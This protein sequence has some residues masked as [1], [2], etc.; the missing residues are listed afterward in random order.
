MIR[1][2]DHNKNRGSTFTVLLGVVA[3][4]AFLSVTAYQVISGP[5]RTMAQTSNT[6]ITDLQLLSTGRILI[7]TVLNSPTSGNCDSDNFVEATPFVTPA[8]G[9]PAPSGGGVIP[10]T[11]I[12]ISDRDAFGTQIGY[13]VWD[14]GTDTNTGTCTGDN[15]LDGSNDPLAGAEQSRTAFA[16]ISAGPNRRFETTCHDF[17]SNPDLITNTA[18]SDDFIRRFNYEEAVRLSGDLWSISATDSDIVEIDRD[19]ELT[20]PNGL[21]TFSAN[22]DVRGRILARGGL[23]VG[24]EGDGA[25]CSSTDDAGTLRFNTSLS[26]LEFCDGTAFVNA[27]GSG[28]GHSSPTILTEQTIV[29]EQTICNGTVTGRL[30]Y[31]T[32]TQRLEFCDGIAFRALYTENNGPTHV[33]PFLD[34]PATPFL[35]STITGPVTAGNP[36]PHTSSTDTLFIDHGGGPSFGPITAYINNTDNFEIID[37]QCSGLTIGSNETDDD[38]FCEITARARTQ[39][40]VNGTFQGLLVLKDATTTVTY[41]LIAVIE[42]YCEAGTSA[43]GGVIAGCTDD[44]IYVIQPLGCGTATTNPIC[45]G[46]DASTARLQTAT[47]ST[48]YPGTNSALDGITNTTDQATDTGSIGFP[49]AEYCHDLVLNG[50]SDWFLPSVSELSLFFYNITPITTQYGIA[51]GTFTGSSGRM[52]TSSSRIPTPNTSNATSMQ[53]TFFLGFR[54]I[55]NPKTS[56]ERV[57]CMRRVAR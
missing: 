31:N 17:A 45:D 4:V 11:N 8:T 33:L 50:H 16:L 27:N 22:V 47:A 46:T 5:V 57:L 56:T 40:G 32:N 9:E 12:G 6:R 30:R 35:F 3:L 54:A 53:G 21:A 34:F 24:T 44:F 41:P 20:S 36:L 19:I 26:N 23:Q 38:I 48:F 29:S 2:I 1:N 15:R 18:G 55:S 14:L 52:W 49:A 51:E 39:T 7:Q 13:C 42:D 25:T 43:E 10:R 37:D 28:S